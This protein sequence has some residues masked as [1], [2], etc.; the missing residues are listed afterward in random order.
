MRAFSLLVGTWMR[1]KISFPED[2]MLTAGRRAENQSHDVNF[3]PF[4]T[5]RASLTHAAIVLC[6]AAPGRPRAPAAHVPVFPVA[7]AAAIQFPEPRGRP[8]PP[9]H[10]R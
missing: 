7:R 4:L 9:P 8:G 3:R 5:G 10:S 1:G 2:L 6:L